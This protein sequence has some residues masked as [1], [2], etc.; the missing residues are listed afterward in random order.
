M[1]G[2]WMYVGDNRTSRCQRT[3]LV[4]GDGRHLGDLLQVGATFEENAVAGAG[5]NGAEH[6]GWCADDQGAR[7]GHDQ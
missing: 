1:A 7:T 3:R 5:G 2:K 4:K 6:A